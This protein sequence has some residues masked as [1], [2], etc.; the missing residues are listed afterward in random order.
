[1]FRKTKVWSFSVL[2][3]YGIYFQYGSCIFYYYFF[4]D[5]ATL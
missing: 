4:S 3:D 5:L 2:M 1:M